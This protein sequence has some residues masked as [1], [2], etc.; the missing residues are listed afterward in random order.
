MGQVSLGVSEQAGTTCDRVSIILPRLDFIY[1]ISF[2]FLPGES[3]RLAQ[4]GC[5][6][7][8]KI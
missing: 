5:N 7:A 1:F 8:A 4:D 3:I 2:H 6:Q